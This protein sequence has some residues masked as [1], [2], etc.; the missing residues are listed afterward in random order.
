MNGTLYAYDPGWTFA[1]T[2]LGT[3][4]SM[5]VTVTDSVQFVELH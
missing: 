1:S 5:H 2:S 4:T 3:A